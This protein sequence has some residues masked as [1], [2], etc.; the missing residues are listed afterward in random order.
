MRKTINKK[1][2]NTPNVRYNRI[3]QS[4]RKELDLSL[5]EYCLADSIYFLSHQRWCDAS[6]EYFANMF[7][8]TRQTIHNDLI[9]LLD[10]GLIEKNPDGYGSLKTTDK[11]ANLVV[12]A[13]ERIAKNY[14]EKNRLIEA[15]R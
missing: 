8:V 3:I 5:S 15:N 6:K 1:K 11:W 9:K 7:G 2:K 13:S 4:V 10:K 12:L 14:K